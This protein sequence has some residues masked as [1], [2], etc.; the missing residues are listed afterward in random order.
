MIGLVTR[1]TVAAALVAAS[2]VAVVAGVVMSVAGG[3]GAARAAGGPG[4]GGAGVPSSPAQGLSLAQLAGQRIVYAYSGLTPPA[5]L[6]ALIRA[7]EAGGVIFFAPNVASSKQ[8]KEVVDELQRAAA[9]SPVHAPLLLMADQEGGLVRRLPGAPTLSEQRIGESANGLSL[10]TAAGAGA[11]RAL[12]AAG[13]N[14]NLAPVLDVARSPSGFDGQYQR[15]YGA[16]AN[17]DAGLGAAFITAQQR[18]GVAATAKHFPGLGAASRTQNTD[19]GPVTL[20]LPL[21]ALR[22]ADEAPF[23]AAIDAGVKLVMLSWAI[24]PALDPKLPAGLSKKVIGGELRTRLGFRGV[25]VTDSLSAAA[26]SAFGSVGARGVLAAAAGA[27][28]LVAAAPHPD[29]NTPQEGAAVMQALTAALGRQAS[30]RTGSEQS[31]NRTI[32]LRGQL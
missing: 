25:T 29:E 2:V 3:T 24:Y 1:R 11:G 22:A 7:G 12:A 26:L 14:V 17:R 23:G 20:N 16:S 18:T 10:A 30:L 21:H 15:S 6:L 4:T 19:L 13:L 32:A 27:D 28:L 8:L 31:V 5:Q 9:A